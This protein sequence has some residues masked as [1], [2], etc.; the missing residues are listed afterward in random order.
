MLCH[1]LA[2]SGNYGNLFL[3]MKMQYE[4]LSKKKGFIIPLRIDRKK[5]R[6]HLLSS[7]GKPNGNHR[8][9]FF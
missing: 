4:M 9:E 5:I 1:V 8:Y 2:Y 7:L 6:D 3:N